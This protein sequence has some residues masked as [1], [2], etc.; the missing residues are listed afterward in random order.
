MELPAKYAGI[1]AAYAAAVEAT[2]RLMSLS[3]IPRESSRSII[4]SLRKARIECLIKLL[5]KIQAEL[6]AINLGELH[7]AFYDP[8]YPDMALIE[9]PTNEGVVSTGETPKHKHQEILRTY[10]V[11][12]L[13]RFY[14]YQESTVYSLVLPDSCGFKKYSF[15]D[16]LVSKTSD[17]EAYS[18]EWVYEYLSPKGELRGTPE[19]LVD[20]SDELLNVLIKTT[21]STSDAEVVK[22]IQ[23]CFRDVDNEHTVRRYE[24]CEQERRRLE[25]ILESLRDK[26]RKAGSPLRPLI[27][28]KTVRCLPPDTGYQMVC[29]DTDAAS[30]VYFNSNTDSELSWWH[31]SFLANKKRKTVGRTTFLQVATEAPQRLLLAADLEPEIYNAI[32]TNAAQMGSIDLSHW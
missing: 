28:V 23:E 12:H 15:L 24:P 13:Q 7:H 32:Q 29:Y 18:L 17:I 4:Y 9:K 3:R 16:D 21:V 27:H 19:R 11:P 1:D 14:V 20:L 5:P 2:K 26:L 8:R 31:R 6:P 22:L 10:F 25:R 30:F